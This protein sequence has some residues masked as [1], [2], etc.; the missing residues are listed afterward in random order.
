LAFSVERGKI[1][2]NDLNAHP[3]IQ[4]NQMELNLSVPISSKALG[5]ILD[6]HAQELSRGVGETLLLAGVK[7][8]QVDRVVYVG[9]SSLMSTVSGT[10]R[11][12]FPDAQ[13]TFSEVFTAVAD[14]LSIAA[15]RTG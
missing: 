9:G 15:S 6:K 7:A 2:A 11:S 13:H 8:A 5:S 10:L 14:G 4:L 3:S 1:A 12:L